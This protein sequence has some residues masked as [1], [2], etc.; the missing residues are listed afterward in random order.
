MVREEV[1]DEVGA[2]VGG[3]GVEVVAG[4]VHDGGAREAEMGEQGGVGER[5]ES[6]VGARTELDLDGEGQPREGG[7]GG[8]LVEDERDEGGVDLW[9]DGVAQGF[10]EGVAEPVGAGSGEG[11]AACCEDEGSGTDG[12]GL[13]GDGEGVGRGGIVGD[14]LGAVGMAEGD[15]GV[16]GGGEEG[17]ED[18]AGFV[19]G[20]EEFAGVFAFEFDAQVFEE[21]DGVVN[22]EPAEDVSDAVSRGAGVGMFGDLVVGDVA[23]AAACD[24]DFGA[25]LLGTVDGKNGWVG[26]RG[27]AERSDRPACGDGGHEP[28]GAG[29]EDSDVCCDAGA[30]RV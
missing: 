15:A 21:A 28:G 6:L 7:E 13:G 23:S 9:R 20:W 11:L 10:G 16:V 19:G 24:E 30:D 4:D 17:V 18:G 8:G 12:G 29:T 22:A 2:G 25:E 3:A 5:F 26:A 27:G 14:G 1:G